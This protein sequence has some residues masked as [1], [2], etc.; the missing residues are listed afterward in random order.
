[1]ERLYMYN[2][3]EKYI[4][5]IGDLIMP[6]I[7]MP[8]L[9]VLAALTL[10]ILASACSGSKPETINLDVSINAGMMIPN[11]IVVKH[12]DTLVM[13]LSSDQQGA[14]HIHGYD[15]KLDVTP[16]TESQLIF[17]SDATGMYKIAFHS[18]TGHH[19]EEKESSEE[20]LH[21]HG[22]TSTDHSEPTESDSSKEEEFVIGYLEVR[23]R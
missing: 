10:V 21:D 3:S 18:D 23:P 13:N 9:S 4:S 19:N 6:K 7:S 5:Q 8:A 22:E 11:K 15:I 1:M 12:N 16:K 2:V 17:K 20:N 14:I